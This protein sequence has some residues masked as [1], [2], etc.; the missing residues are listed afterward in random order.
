MTNELIG[1]AESNKVLPLGWRLY[2]DTVERDA[3]FTSFA[4]NW[5]DGYQLN[6]IMG[7]APV[8]VDTASADL[9]GTLGACVEALDE[10][11]AQLGSDMGHPAICHFVK[12]IANDVT[13]LQTLSLTSQM[14]A[15]GAMTTTPTDPGVELPP[16]AQLKTDNTALNTISSIS[17]KKTAEA[18]SEPR[19]EPPSDPEVEDDWDL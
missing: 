2:G 14:W 3:N 1:K 7:W 10:D 12:A 5:T 17:N 16:Y 4:S 15:N 9:E 13:N 19:F 18:D 8:D 6:A 11:G